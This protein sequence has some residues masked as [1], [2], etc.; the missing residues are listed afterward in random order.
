MPPG[1]Q[2]VKPVQDQVKALEEV[3]VKLG[4]LDVCVVRCDAHVGLERADDLRCCDCLAAA[5]VGLAE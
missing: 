1:V 3:D 4:V 2:V 5:D